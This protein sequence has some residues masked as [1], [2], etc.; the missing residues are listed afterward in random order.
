[1]LAGLCSRLCTV[2]GGGGVVAVMLGE[3]GL[4][5][6]VACGIKPKQKG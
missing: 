3:S 2:V 4:D 5:L 6:D 1:V